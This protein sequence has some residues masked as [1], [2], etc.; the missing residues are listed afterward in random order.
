MAPSDGE[1]SVAH[2]IV[3]VF[4]NSGRGVAVV[5]G[6]MIDEPVVAQARKILK[7]RA[8]ERKT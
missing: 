6:K 2:E 7:Q 8:R 1:I 3:S 5:R 4:E